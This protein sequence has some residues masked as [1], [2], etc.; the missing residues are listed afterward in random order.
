MKF[1][2]FFRHTAGHAQA[3]ISLTS[4]QVFD[5]VSCLLMNVVCYFF[6]SQEAI[7]VPWKSLPRRVSKLYLA[8]RGMI[9]GLLICFYGYPRMFIFIEH[10]YYMLPTMKSNC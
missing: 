5:S 4:S 9:F 2:N 7:S 10:F 6:P 3:P 8:M 1:R